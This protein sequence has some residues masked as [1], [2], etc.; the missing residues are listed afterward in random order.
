[1]YPDKHLRSDGLSNF[2][3]KV[4]IFSVYNNL[5]MCLLQQP[6]SKSERIK[7]LAEIV[8]ELDSNNEKA[9]Y[10]HGQACIRLK[11]FDRAKTSFMKVASISGGQYLVLLGFRQVLL[12]IFA[13]KNK[14]VARWLAECETE[15]EKS[16]EKE[17]KMYQA[18]FKPKA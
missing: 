15:L 3:E 17:N 11:D 1:M 13:G 10:R 9:W 18:M 4:C 2:T 16:R 14:E 5:C 6:D 7:E 8:I 12:F